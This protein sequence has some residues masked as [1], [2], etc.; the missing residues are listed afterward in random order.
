MGLKSGREKLAQVMAKKNKKL[1]KKQKKKERA[2][3]IKERKSSLA[4]SE[5]D[6]DGGKKKLKPLDFTPKLA[7]LADSDGT[8]KKAET[9]KKEYNEMLK[10]GREKLAQVMAKKN[11]K[12]TKKTEEKKTC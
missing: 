11:K 2:E 4:A 8:D 7:V 5:D 9:D 12:L 6:R 1:T 3:F 10:S